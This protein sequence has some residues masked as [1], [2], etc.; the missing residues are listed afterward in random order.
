MTDILRNFVSGL[1]WMSIQGIQGR[2][3]PERAIFAH[4]AETAHSG[5]IY[6]IPSKLQD[7][8]LATGVPILADFK[9]IPYRRGEV[10]SW[11][12]RVR[13]LEWF[14][15]DEIDCGLMANFID[16]YGVTHMVLGPQQL[17]QVC[18]EMTERYNDGY[19]AVYELTRSP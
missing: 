19:Y 11:H 1:A 2:I 14:Y 6:A 9:S 4:V 7:F 13:L 12:D 8:R 17:G 3:V 5:Q 18:P 10:I 16:E 15:R